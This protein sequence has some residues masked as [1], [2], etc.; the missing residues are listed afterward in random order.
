MELREGHVGGLYYS[1]VDIVPPWQASET[2][3]FHHGVGANSDI[4]CE[5]IPVLADRYRIVRFDMRGMGRSREA[6]HENGLPFDVLVNDVISVADA[7]G[8]ERFHFVGES[9]GGTVA[10]V[11]G[12]EFPDRA[13]TITVSNAAHVGSAIRNI[14]A[15]ERVLTGE[16]GPAWSA[17][18]MDHRFFPDDLSQDKR[19]WYETQQ[20]QHPTSAI[21]AGL[22]SLVGVDLRDKLSDLELSVLLLQADASPF[23]SAAEMADL[24]ARLPRSQLQVF[25]H[26][27]HGLP[28][29][30]P[31][32][33]AKALRAF[34]LRQQ[35]AG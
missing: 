23:V 7:V 4:W 34:L 32:A 25:P 21:L 10:L 11:V 35:D 27:R 24:H 33:C 29:S 16:G 14:E 9:I 22:N 17:M 5:W 15:W 30:H 20:G 3:I 28:F 13:R 12:A 8:A 6:D 26:A 18:L 31:V 2:I 19:A 1:L